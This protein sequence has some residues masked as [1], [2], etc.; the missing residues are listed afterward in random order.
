MNI[1]SIA[2]SDPSSGAG[3]QSDVRTFTDLGAH[4]LTV[5]TSIT[6]QNTTKFGKVESVSSKMIKNQIDSVFSDF[7]IDAIKIGMIFD[8]MSIKAIYSKIYKINIPI[9]LDP[10]LKSTTGG[11]L[12]KKNAYEDY[13]KY[14]IPI[15]YVITPNVLEASILSGIK[16]KNKQDIEKSALK[17]KELG[18]K[19]VVITGM[20][21]ENNSISDFVFNGKKLYNVSGKLIRI[22]NHGSGCNFSAALTV[23]IAKKKNILNAVKIAKKY[24]F[25]S[26]K[27][28]KKAGKGIPI[29]YSKNKSDSNRIILENAINDFVNLK[30]I[31]LLIPE[32]Q[33]NFVYSKNSI[34]SINDVLGIAGRIVKTGNDVIVAG[35][36]QYGGSKHVATALIEV[37]KKFPEIRSA[38]NIKYN[39]NLIKRLKK[40]SF[41]IKNYDRQKEPD[42]IKRK[43]NSSISWGIKQA[44]K[45]SHTPPDAIYH[46]GGLG[47]EPMIMIFG[48]NPDQVV[49]K[50]TKIL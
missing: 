9:I 40:K 43:E 20:K 28:A 27:N 35:D 29:T 32:C 21:I 16:I 44:L 41:V 17:L 22:T 19:N 14:L 11:I 46:T 15:S 37:N 30:K 49:D 36:L 25:D 7:K 33:T 24:T 38:L 34:K 18:T 48:I 45:S 2:G 1:L 47:K 39:S 23:A 5:I 4:A 10:V 6:S 13:K 50:I 3:I 8:T 12:L 42:I 26:I 31:N